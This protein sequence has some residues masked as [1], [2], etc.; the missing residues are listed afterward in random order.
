MH[1]RL[2][3]LI[4]VPAFAASAALVSCS[5]PDRPAL[6]SGECFPTA[7][8][9]CSV[10]LGSGGATAPVGGPSATPGP[11]ATD[12]AGTGSATDI[13]S[14]PGGDSGTFAPLFDAG[15]PSDFFP[16][17]L[18]DGGRTINGAAR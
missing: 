2:R 12:D 4:L 16:T 6:E 10:A 11:G 15:Q 9:S 8:T 7:E 3:C 1:P 18:A 14:G 17:D 5:D 13:P